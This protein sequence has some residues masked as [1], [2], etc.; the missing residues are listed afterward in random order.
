M[1][2]LVS[3]GAVSA[4]NSTCEV[5][6]K[7][8]YEYPDDINPTIE[9]LTDS[10]GQE[11]EFQKYFDPAANITKITFQHPQPEK[12]FNITIKAPGYQTTTKQFTPTKNPTNP[13]DP[14]YYTHLQI[15]LKATQTYKIGREITKKANQ[16]LNFTK[17]GKVLVITTAGSAYYK[18]STSEDALE[19]ILNQAQGIISYGKGNLLLLRKTRL[20]PLDFAFITRK[21]NDLILVYFKNA[22]LT[23]TYIGT[24][25]QNMTKAQWNNLTQKLGSDA[26][27]IASLANAWALG[28]PADILR[29]AAFHGH[30]CLGTISG[31][32]MIETL[33][34]YYPPSTGTG[35][36]EATSYIVIGVPGGSDDDVFVYAMDSTPGKRAYIGYNTTD[37]ANMVGFI[38]WNS[39]TRTGILIIMTYNWTELTEQF[40]RETK[41]TVE[42]DTVTELK[43][44]AWAIQK[45]I[46]SP[47][48]LVKILYAFDNNRRTS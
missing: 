39:N 28:L 25:S 16:I 31:Y 21:G 26:F 17:T 23:P 41:A 40:R 33:L 12:G 38:R 20:D 7:I 36:A 3:V 29:E 13:Q 15:Q 24:V 45:L 8:T 37:D 1:T 10:N 4:T 22:S 19:G 34:K 35:G 46:T 30:V 11:I 9:K 44:N 27:P 43:F 32:A 6:L 42:E 18:N 14:K 5:G 2:S 47:E 48:S